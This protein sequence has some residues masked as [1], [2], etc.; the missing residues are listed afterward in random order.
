MAKAVDKGYE[1]KAIHEVWHFPRSH[2]GLFKDYV[3]AWLKI[4]EE[5]SGWPRADMTETEKQQYLGDYERREGIRLDHDKMEKNPGL[6]ALAKMIL[7][8]M[9]G[10][11]GQRENKTQV[12][13]FV[14]PQSMHTFLDSDGNDIR[15]VS[16]L[17]EERVEVHFKKEHDDRGVSPNLNIFVAAFTTCWARLRLYEA[18]ELLDE[19]VLYFDTDSVIFIHRPGE[20]DPP[21]GEYLGDFKNELEGDDAI[22]EFCS[23]GPKNYGY[24]T[25]RGETCCKVRGFSLNS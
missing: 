13:E 25:R 4:K 9:W 2:V 21:L 10:K 7:N 5:T 22:V 1:I 23:G 6:R 12:K 11:F 20:P 15:Y 17:T 3:N 18:L 8:S 19:R 16:P 14:D 24:R